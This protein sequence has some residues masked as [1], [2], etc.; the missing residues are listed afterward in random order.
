MQCVARLH[1]LVCASAVFYSHT[2]YIYI[3]YSYCL[4]LLV[5]FRRAGMWTVPWPQR[6]PGNAAGPA[7]HF[8]TSYSE[9]AATN[10]AGAR[11]DPTQ[12]IPTATPTSVAFIVAR[13]AQSPFPLFFPFFFPSRVTIP[14]LLEGCRDQVDQYPY[15]KGATIVY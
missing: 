9:A 8:A 12:S 6:A 1:V 2:I 11:A 10:G 7:S 5:L 15:W 3:S 13:S 4:L 14:L